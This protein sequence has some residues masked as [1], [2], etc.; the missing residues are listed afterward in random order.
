[1]DRGVI[2]MASELLEARQYPGVVALVSDALDDAPYCVPLLLIRAR[3]HTALRRDLDAQA[4]LRDI[5]RL[6]PSCVAAFRLLGE[7]ATRR[8]E[9]EA[10]ATFF[11]EA[12]RLDPDDLAAADWL[13]V[14]GSS[15]RPAAVASNLPAP[16]TAAGRVLLPAPRPH[17]EPRFAKGTQSDDL[18]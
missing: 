12:L 16:A 18:N 6:D 14:V 3:A 13:L 9:N 7:L 2:M 5:I 1:M 10:A 15:I 17:S 8:D 4:D 11:R